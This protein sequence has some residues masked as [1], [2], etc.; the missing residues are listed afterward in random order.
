LL[1]KDSTVVLDSIVATTF[2]KT[3]WN[4]KI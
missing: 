2:Y 3:K 4:K 1:A